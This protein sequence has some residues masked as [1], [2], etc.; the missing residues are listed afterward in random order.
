MNYK[1]NILLVEDDTVDIKSVKRA[2]KELNVT[3]PLVVTNNGE[4]AIKYL[5][6]NSNN[7]PAL[8]LL[9]LNMPRMNGLEFLKIIKKNDKFK[10]TPVIALTTSDEDRD[11]T[12]S[13]NSGISGY[14]LK[15]V[16]YKDFVEVIKTIRLYWT[17]S[18]MP[19]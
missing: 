11:K 16:D 18:E 2:F 12:E 17:L 15:P 13:F 6:K 9:D 1:Q 4:D 14:M 19:Q 10:K 5:M 3:N 8:I 7:L